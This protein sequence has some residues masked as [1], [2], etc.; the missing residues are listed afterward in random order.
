LIVFQYNIRYQRRLD[1][2][3]VRYIFLYSNVQAMLSDSNLCLL[4]VTLYSNSEFAI[5]YLQWFRTTPVIR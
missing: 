5:D 2:L 3:Y 4:A 1:I